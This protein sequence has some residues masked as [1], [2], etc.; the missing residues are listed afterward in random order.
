MAVTKNAPLSVE[1]LAGLASKEDFTA[2]KLK[3]AGNAVRAKDFPHPMLIR[4]KGK[5]Q[6]QTR[7]VAPEV[8]SL[9]SG[10]NYIL[11]TSN[12]VI[13]TAL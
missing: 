7:V 6:V 3:K 12:K 4:I 8:A 11:L 5:R 1:A 13:Y 9:S 10:D 2:V